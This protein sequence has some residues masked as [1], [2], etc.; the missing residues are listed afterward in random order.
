[1]DADRYLTG[2]PSDLFKPHVILPSQHFDP[3]KK[4]APEH[5]LPRERKHLSTLSLAILTAGTLA[6]WWQATPRSAWAFPSNAEM[7]TVGSAP[8]GIP[9]QEFID[10]PVSALARE[11]LL[12]QHLDAQAHGTQPVRRG[13]EV[14]LFTPGDFGV[15]LRYRW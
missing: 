5:R 8:V 4:F 6:L 14:E 10:K 13:I 12:Q 9:V 2:V 3:P 1:M 11:M 7:R 15:V